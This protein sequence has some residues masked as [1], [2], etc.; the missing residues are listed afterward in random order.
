MKLCLSKL[1]LLVILGLTTLNLGCLEN[2]SDGGSSSQAT[3]SGTAATGLP[4]QGFVFI[5]DAE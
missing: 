3:L 5:R 2:G 1:P 4:L